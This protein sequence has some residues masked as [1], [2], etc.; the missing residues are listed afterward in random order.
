MSK[1]TSW[2]TWTGPKLLLS[3]RAERM[4]SVTGSAFGVLR[5]GGESRRWPDRIRPGHRHNRRSGDPEVL[6]FG[7]DSL[8]DLVSLQRAGVDDV[9]DVGLGD[10][11]GR[12]EQRLQL[13]AGRLRV[14]ERAQG[15][16][17]VGRVLALRED[18]GELRG[19]R[20]LERDVLED[21][22]ALLAGDDVLQALDA[23]VLAGD[24]HVTV[25]AA[26]L[27]YADDRV[28]DVVVG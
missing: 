23:G 9:R 20:G 19:R 5:C 18:D 2:R 8:A 15:Q 24:D 17:G 28:G 14:V 1:S 26:G 21:R 11:L 16:P 13:V 10:D 25:E 22:H 4:G 27:E 7:L 12:Q 6:T 3:L